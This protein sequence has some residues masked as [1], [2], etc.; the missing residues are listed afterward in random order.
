MHQPV[1]WNCFC[2]LYLLGSLGPGPPRQ[3]EIELPRAQNIKGHLVQGISWSSWSNQY[4]SNSFTWCSPHHKHAGK[5]AD[6]ANTLTYILMYGAEALEIEVPWSNG[7][8]LLVEPVMCRP[9]HLPWCHRHHFLRQRSYFRLQKSIWTWT[10]A[11]K[12]IRPCRG[13]A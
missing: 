13:A 6:T 3:D 5:N 4:M 11:S 12:G 1:E 9:T 10:G 8:F 7:P 2:C